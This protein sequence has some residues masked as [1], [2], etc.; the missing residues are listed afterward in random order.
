MTIKLPKYVILKNGKNLQYQ[1]KVPK[2]LSE[3]TGCNPVYQ[4]ALG[5]TL[6]ASETQIHSAV[7]KAHESYELHCKMLGNSDRSALEDTE[8][9]LAAAE[10]LRTIRKNPG[11]YAW[12]KNRSEAIDQASVDIFGN[13]EDIYHLETQEEYYGELD[14][15]D[16]IKRRAAEKL[17]QHA[18]KKPKTIGSV[19]NSY[20][21]AKELEGDDRNSSKVKKRVS[22]LVALVGDS[23]IND[24]TGDLLH[25]ALRQYRDERLTNKVTVSTIKREMNDLMGFIK[26]CREEYG[27]NWH[28]NKPSLPAHKAKP[29][30]PL[31]KA[32]QIQFISYCCNNLETHK[33]RIA[34]CISLI[35]LQ[36][37]L[38]QSEIQRM[39]PDHVQLEKEIPYLLIAGDT[40]TNQ[41]KRLV[42]IVLGVDFIKANFWEA[43]S[44]LNSVTESAVSSMLKKFLQRATGKPSFTAHC[45]RHTLRFNT[46]L[47]HVPY[48]EAA[49]IGGWSGGSIS[50]SEHMLRYGAEGIEYAERVAVIQQTSLRIHRHL[51]SPELD[52]HNTSNV[53]DISMAS[54]NA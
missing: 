52:R 40:K 13:D 7:G 18:S 24:S 23:I 53:I 34:A 33:D 8:L 5:L 45:L 43:H 14:L 27:F 16:E 50:V 42:P 54:M 36:G 31:N 49:S 6:S 15:E 48:S 38:M 37:G 29:R 17:L 26:W 39:T 2:R 4:K 9:D 10:L 3:A 11:Q 22:R 47:N 25:A 20:I 28:I 12:L 46:D 21:K 30:H 19:Y 44:Y 32:E 35:E 1:R 51:L 41:R